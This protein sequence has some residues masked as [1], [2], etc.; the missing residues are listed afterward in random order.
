MDL[1]IG[2]D[3]MTVK[4]N[5]IAI[6]FTAS[7]TFS[8]AIDQVA[9]EE[10]AKLIIQRLGRSLNQ[11]PVWTMEIGARS[12]EMQHHRYEIS[13]GKLTIGIDYDSG[14]VMSFQDLELE[15]R[16]MN[17]PGS[18][19]ASKEGVPKYR[20]SSEYEQLARSIFNSLDLDVSGK[21][22]ARGLPRTDNEGAVQRQQV[23]VDF[24]E[25]H[26]GFDVRGGNTVQFS[27]DS[28]S[29]ELVSFR[30]T[31]GFTLDPPDSILGRARI[32]ELARLVFGV[33]IEDNWIEGP[34]YQ[35][36]SESFSL[37]DRGREFARAKR[38]PLVYC[39]SNERLLVFF[40]ADTG[41]ELGRMTG[42][43]AGTTGVDDRVG[44]SS[45]VDSSATSHPRISPTLL[46]LAFGV[47]ILIGWPLVRWIHKRPK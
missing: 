26:E 1:T 47:V 39:V 12:S 13:I 20:S 43:H 29:G 14:E 25:E 17:G 24:S 31:F 45:R 15:A 11:S 23:F 41:E 3:A 40:A 35:Q 18:E 19:T 4:L 27:F 33:S 36:L 22:S 37:S 21:A 10:R 16:I 7:T 28:V 9:A 34:V 44:S 2:K 42:G 30:R 46:W 8:F 5:L 6:I 38:L 32:A